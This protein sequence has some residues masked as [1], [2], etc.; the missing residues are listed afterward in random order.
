LDVSFGDRVPSSVTGCFFFPA[1]PIFYAEVV[2]RFTVAVLVVSAF[3]WAAPVEFLGMG[4]VLDA[5]GKP[6][7]VGTYAAPLMVDWDG[8]G[9][10][11]LIVGQFEGG[12]IRFYPNSGIP[13]DPS[14]EE[15]QYLRD[16]GS[17]LSVPYG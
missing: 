17:L 8:D 1:A 14:F 15:F 13:G 2:M 3:L 11:D 12:Q 10:E 5:S 16:G 4:P 6:I 7:D 9:L